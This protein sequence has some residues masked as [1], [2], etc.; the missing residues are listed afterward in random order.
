MNKQIKTRLKRIALDFDGAI[1]VLYDII[2]PVIEKEV[3]SDAYAARL[4]EELRL[5]LER[6]K[7][8]KEVILGAIKEDEAMLRTVKYQLENT[9][10]FVEEMTL[11][12]MLAGASR[13]DIKQAVIHAVMVGDRERV[14]EGLREGIEQVESK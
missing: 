10:L 9:S 11:A 8:E 4:A 2:L 1:E 12:K 14:L 13:D 6:G 3:N 5:Y 7:A